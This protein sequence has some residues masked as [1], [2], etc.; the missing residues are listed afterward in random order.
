M[1]ISTTT[2]SPTFLIIK[3]AI[4]DWFNI[5]QILY[6]LASYDTLHGFNKLPIN[7]EKKKEVLFSFELSVTPIIWVDCLSYTIDLGYKS[8]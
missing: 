2:L 6:Y 7:A 1:N 8:S 4:S 5:L 3:Q